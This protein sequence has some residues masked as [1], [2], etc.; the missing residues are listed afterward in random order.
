MP[1]RLDH[2]PEAPE[3]RQALHLT[4]RD[5]GGQAAAF[6]PRPGRT[7][8]AAADVAVP[9]YPVVDCAQIRDPVRGQAGPAPR[10]ANAFQPDRL[11]GLLDLVDFS[12]GQRPEQELLAWLHLASYHLSRADDGW[13]RNRRHRRQR[14]AEYPQSRP[15]VLDS[16]RLF[17][18]AEPHVAR[19]PLR[20]VIEACVGQAVVLQARELWLDVLQAVA[21]GRHGAVAPASG[22]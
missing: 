22:C 1:G 15:A 20:Q 18:V 8:P 19:A 7:E 17:A 2:E 3:S 9:G 6:P 10:D 16:M 11:C 13:P 21:R 5:A 4:H 12:V 14:M